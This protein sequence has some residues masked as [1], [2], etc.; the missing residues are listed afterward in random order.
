MLFVG[1]GDPNVVDQLDF[2]AVRVDLG[3]G[4]L[5]VPRVFGAAVHVQVRRGQQG[6]FAGLEVFDLVGGHFVLQLAVGQEL[7]AVGVDR[8]V[9]DGAFVDLGHRLVEEAFRADIPV[10]DR[11]QQGGDHREQRN[12]A[13]FLAEHGQPYR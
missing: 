1:T 12:V 6:D 9:V 3:A 7:H 4:A 10:A 13:G 11:H 5:H 8:I 2:A